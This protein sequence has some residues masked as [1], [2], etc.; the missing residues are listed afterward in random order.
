MAVSDTHMG[1]AIQG[2]WM[3][4]NRP[5]VHPQPNEKPPTKPW[6]HPPPLPLP[7]CSAGQGGLSA[8]CQQVDVGDRGGEPHEQRGGL[9]QVHGAD[10]TIQSSIGTACIGQQRQ[11]AAQSAAMRPGSACR[12]SRNR[13]NKRMMNSFQPSPCI[14]RHQPVFSGRLQVSSSS[15][16]CGSVA[17]AAAAGLLLLLP[18]PPFFPFLGFIST[19]VSTLCHTTSPVSGNT[20][21]RP[22]QQTG[23][24][25]GRVFHGVCIP[26]SQDF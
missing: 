4:G 20:A 21:R 7:T 18:P 5:V 19:R 15:V 9:V 26:C 1:I 6:Q 11:P 25:M 23:Q 13:Y 24:P 2:T 16:G 3:A 17:A 8:G 14:C 12:Q 10:V 22:C